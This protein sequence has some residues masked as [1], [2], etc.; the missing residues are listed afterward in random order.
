[1][2]GLRTTLDTDSDRGEEQTAQHALLRAFDAARARAAVLGQAGAAET[3]EATPPRAAARADRRAELRASIEREERDVARLSTL[4][5]NFGDVF[6]GIMRPG[7]AGC[8]RAWPGG[9]PSRAG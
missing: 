9:R 2:Q 7:G 8:G 1:M 4:A 3:Q 6:R 5:R